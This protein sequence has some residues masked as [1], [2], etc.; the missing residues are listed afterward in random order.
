[1]RGRDA[2]TFN[3]VDYVTSD[4]K[5]IDDTSVFTGWLPTSGSAT[6]SAVRLLRYCGSQ[7]RGL[8]FCSRQAEAKELA[9]KLLPVIRRRFDQHR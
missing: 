2:G 6:C 3:Y 9:V 1:M 5:T 7:A 8:V 4:G